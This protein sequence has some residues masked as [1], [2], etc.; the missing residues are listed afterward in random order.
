TAALVDSNVLVTSAS[1]LTRSLKIPNLDCS[2]NIFAVFPQTNIQTQQVFRCDRV[3]EADVNE[4][5]DK[6]LWRSDLAFIKLKEAPSRR[7]LDISRE[8]MSDQAKYT[9]W[10]SSYLSDTDSTLSA[11]NC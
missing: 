8:G 9:V 1:C 11:S 7:V 3:L 5:V 10:K 2:E 4:E 6:A